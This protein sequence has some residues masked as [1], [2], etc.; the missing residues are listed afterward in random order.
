[1]SSD[2][3]VA[4]YVVQWCHV[5][6]F[7]TKLRSR[8][9]QIRELIILAD[10][11]T[12]GQFVTVRAVHQNDPD[13]IVIEDRIDELRSQYARLC[14]RANHGERLPTS[15]YDRFARCARWNERLSADAEGMTLEQYREMCRD[16]VETERATDAANTG[17]NAVRD[18]TDLSNTE[19]P[20]GLFSDRGPANST[21]PPDGFISLNVDYHVLD[22]VLSLII[23]VRDD[24]AQLAQWAKLAKKW[25]A[26]SRS[27]EYMIRRI[28]HV[29]PNTPD[30]IAVINALVSASRSIAPFEHV[31]SR[32]HLAQLLNR[33]ALINDAEHARHKI[34][35][36]ISAMQRITDRMR[37][38]NTASPEPLKLPADGPI[39]PNQF[40]WRGKI[41]TLQPKPAALLAMI[42]DAPD[43][44][45]EIEDAADQVWG[46]E[47]SDAAID[48]AYRKAN[49]ALIE[50]GYQGSITKKSG[51][52]ILD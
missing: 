2:D 52:L 20:G 29:E 26:A 18:P 4:F 16:L 38:H 44:R 36:T 35:D 42:W 21:L 46:E 45:I 33:T 28:Q 27:I 5:I 47:K 6:E 8:A 7:A 23:E 1:M 13:R 30:G 48:A 39:P 22:P 19:Q 32:T 25:V 31:E 24:K 40:A 10:G 15:E 14:G 9:D 12:V 50:L 41:A 51:M 11:E 43:R 49:A 37:G 34:R 17:G 3:R